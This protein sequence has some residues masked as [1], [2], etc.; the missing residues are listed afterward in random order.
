M[1]SAITDYLSK[2]KTAL[3]GADPATIRDALADAEEHLTTALELALANGPAVSPSDAIET[4]IDTY[5]S[6]DE[7]AAAYKE[8]ETMTPVTL[9]PPTPSAKARSSGFLGVFGDVHT[10]GALLYMIMSL[11]TGI[12]YFTWAVTGLSLSAGLI[13][14]VIGVPFMAAFLV[15]V[16]G[17]A[18]VEGRIIEG[19]LGER[20]PRRIPFF[21]RDLGW[22]G[23]LKALFGDRTT[24]SA[25][26]YMV[27]QLP[28]GIVYFTTVITLTA[29]SLGL[30]AEPILTYVFGLP[31]VQRGEH[32]Y[33]LPGWSM[34]IVVALGF[35]LLVG[36][37]H[38]VRGL[39]RLHARYA[40][41]LLVKVEG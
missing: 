18:L 21:R 23:G 20:M 35:V 27:L 34:P 29:V 28:L 31:I 37:F 30:M 19:V 25:I 13:V 38:A 7:V 2:L 15:S 40:K 4:I 22:W 14:L 10:Y 26:L 36:T 16:R 17:L 5:G 1:N 11:A 3:A 12:F 39:G 8:M 32:A 33:Y 24:W 41:A 9:A 6:P